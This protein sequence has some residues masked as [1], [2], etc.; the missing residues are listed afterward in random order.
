MSAVKVDVEAI[1]KRFR[2][3]PPDTQSLR[4]VRREIS[5]EL[6]LVDRNTVLTLAN[7]LITAGIARFVAYEL[8]QHH[9]QTAGS[10]TPS[11]IE[12]L[13]QGIHSWGDIDAFACFITGPAW[14]N[15]HIPD[16]LIQTWAHLEDWCWRRV[17]LVSTVPLNSRAQ[18]GTGDTERTLE[19]CRT[20]IEDRTD[21][22]VKALSWAL[23]ELAKR[24]PENVHKFLIAHRDQLAS[25]VLREVGNKLTK[26][27]KNPL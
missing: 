2:H 26:G 11:E 19:L 27:L 15:R 20:L 7:E 6:A 13:G 16:K 4:F 5:R 18:G 12:H 14:R 23:R 8:V 22:V 3:A 17:A 1:V 21:L 25:R 10:L 24:D 9:K